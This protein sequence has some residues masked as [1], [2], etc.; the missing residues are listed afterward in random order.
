MKINALTAAIKALRPER[1]DF[2]VKIHDLTRFI[3]LEVI[4]DLC[5]K[6]RGTVT[7]WR[8]ERSRPCHE[9]GETILALH[10]HFCGEKR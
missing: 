1:V 2:G 4:A 9:D 6:S 8:H 5:H 3:T 10:R 7:D